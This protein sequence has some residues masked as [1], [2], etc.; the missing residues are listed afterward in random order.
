MLKAQVCAIREKK[1]LTFVGGA[2]VVGH[3]AG[4][5]GGAIDMLDFEEQLVEAIGEDD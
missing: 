1:L 2:A 3:A 5:I 4:I